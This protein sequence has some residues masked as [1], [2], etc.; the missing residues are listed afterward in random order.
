MSDQAPLV[1]T[2]EAPVPSDGTAEWF[3]GAGAVRLRAALFLPPG[4]PRGTVVLSG[5][6][7]EPIEKYFEVVGELQQRGFVVLVHDW[8]GQGLSHRLLEDRLKGHAR[9]FR[10]F[11]EDYR[12][13]LAHFGDRLPR[14]WIALGHSMGGCL[15]LL[16]LAHGVGPFKAALLSAPMLG[17]LTGKR[18]KW[19]VRLMAWWKALTEPEAYIQN[20]PGD[21]HGETFEGNIVTHDPRRYAR[22]KGIIA[23]EPELGLNAG[24]WGWLDFALSASA[25]LKRSP[26]VAAIDIPVLVLAAEQEKL[27]DNADQREIVARIPRGRW[28][29]IPGA[30]HELFQETDDIR[31]CV[32]REFDDLAAAL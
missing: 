10:D 4:R 25:W 12:A 3:S 14:P 15:T 26:R 24:T 23:A 8:R 30:Y 1:S 13:L 2:A 22:N 27:V 5:G 17:L 20:N 29:E 31:A 32:W 19:Q 28:I 21:P 9:G 18:P 11:V 6:R 7:T 16:A